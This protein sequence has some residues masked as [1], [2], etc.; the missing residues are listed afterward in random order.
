MKIVKKRMICHCLALMLL[1]GGCSMGPDY[2]RPKLDLPTIR[3]NDKNKIDEFVCIEWWTTFQD[4]TLNKLEGIAVKRNADVKQAIA[5]VEE[6]MAAAGIAMGDLLPSIGLKGEGAKTHLS[7]KSVSGGG[8]YDSFSTKSLASYEIDLFGKYRRA[9]EAARAALLASNAAKS[10]TM[11]V[12]TA[13]VAKAYFAIRALDAK[14]AI[15]RRTLRTRQETHE[16]YKSRMKNGYCTEFDCL[17]VEADMRSIKATVLDLE[18]EFEKA[19]TALSVLIGCSPREIIARRTN[20]TGSIE[21]LRVP[22]NIP[23][24]LPSNLLSRRPDVSQ[25][26]G[27]LMEANA[28]IG[29]AESAH[30]PSLSLT[31]MFGFESLSLRELFSNG[32]DSWNI[33]AGISLPIFNGGKIMFASEAARARY[34]KIR[35][36][37]EKTVQTAFKETL[38]ALVTNKKI[39]EIVISRTAQVNALQKGYQLARKQNEVGLIGLLDLLD[40]ERGLLTAEME[41]VG[42]LQNQLNATVDLCKVLGGGWIDKGN[43]HMTTSVT[44]AIRTTPATAKHK[45]K[46]K[47]KWRKSH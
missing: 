21:S 18:C 9:N 37:Y 24:G 13:S 16:M 12:V 27:L 28:R 5:N 36:S 32:S 10:V 29:V 40:V 3:N 1:M 17:R 25:A 11:L 35:A 41:L 44:S 33:G 39:R 38:D 42:A 31:G 34:K 46:A 22:S 8:Q 14:L 30:L 20:I 43:C 2:R 7:S 23:S 26:E 15:A 6:A 19:E 47:R 4:P 45:T